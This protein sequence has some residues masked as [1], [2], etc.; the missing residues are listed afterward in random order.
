MYI[1]VNQQT[2][3]I[4]FVLHRPKYINNIY[5]KYIKVN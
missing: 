2:N 4:V 5:K 1:L 3:I